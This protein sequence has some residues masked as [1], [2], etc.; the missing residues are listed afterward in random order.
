MCFVP[1]MPPV[2]NTDILNPSDRQ[3]LLTVLESL[4]RDPTAVP[5][6]DTDLFIMLRDAFNNDQLDQLIFVLDTVVQ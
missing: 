6:I 3:W 4:T 2:P 1:N 5:S